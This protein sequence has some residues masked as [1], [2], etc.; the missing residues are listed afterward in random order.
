MTRALLIALTVGSAVVVSAAPRDRG[1]EQQAQTPPPVF[2][3]Q[4]SAVS[5][6]VGV[7]DK[8]RRAIDDLTAA[9]FVVMD[10]GVAQKVDEVSFAKR[11]I[12]VTVALDV[13][14]SV[15]G[16]ML[17]V[18]RRGISDLAHDLRP[19]DRLK[20]V[21][22]NTQV[23]RVTAFTSDLTAIDRAM[24]EVPAGGATAL[25]D[26]AATALI[27]ASDTERRQ[28]VVFFTDGV[29]AGSM[30][31][32]AMLQTVADRTRATVT[33][34]IPAPRTAPVIIPGASSNS[35]GGNLIAP[36]LITLPS[37]SQTSTLSSGVLGQI[38]RNTGGDILADSAGLLGPVFRQ[39]L[40][41]FRSSYVLFYSP[42]GVERTGFHTITVTVT[43]QGATVQAR[44]GYFGG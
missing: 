27:A 38:A 4:G 2:R 29:D 14:G 36:N 7:R 3:A 34:V 30:T 9:D 1:G 17:D 44:R 20:L 10:N 21:V 16:A 39:A 43:R 37:L 41:N 33:I 24:R 8:S 31:T 5:V 28:L 11:P 25:L 6:D 13:S 18:L 35:P 42:T 22:F 32:P 19:A 12:D 15:S 26:T 40:E 23:T